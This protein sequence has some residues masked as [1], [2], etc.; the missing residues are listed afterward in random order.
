MGSAAWASLGNG[1]A[2]TSPGLLAHPRQSQGYPGVSKVHYSSGVPG[3]TPIQFRGK[4]GEGCGRMKGGPG[5]EEVGRGSAVPTDSPGLPNPKRS[6][7][8]VGL[9]WFTSF[10]LARPRH[11]SKSHLSVSPPSQAH[12]GPPGP[13]LCLHCQ[14][15]PLGRAPQ[16]LL[17]PPT[18]RVL[19]GAAPCTLFSISWAWHPVP[20]TVRSNPKPRRPA[21]FKDGVS[22]AF[23]RGSSG[24]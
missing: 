6:H 20:I 13:E 8:H 17:P 15:R 9:S 3:P 1:R 11:S 23:S 14:H 19:L 10:C 12:E 16:T 2:A 24:F 18:P 21:H 5:Q 7:L 4:S 22:F